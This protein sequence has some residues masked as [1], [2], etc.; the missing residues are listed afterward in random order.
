MLG[1]NVNNYLNDLINQLIDYA[2]LLSFYSAYFYTL[3][4]DS[5]FL[6][7]F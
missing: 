5:T 7:N 3:L 4:L 2:T 1:I 6:K